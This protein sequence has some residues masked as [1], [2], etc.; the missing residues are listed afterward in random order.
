MTWN[1][2]TYYTR[3]ILEGIDFKIFIATMGS[4][5]LYAFGKPTAGVYAFVMICGIDFTMGIIIALYNKEFTRQRFF[6]G[7]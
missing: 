4:A 3:A 1:S 5:L 7:I 6:R 2:I